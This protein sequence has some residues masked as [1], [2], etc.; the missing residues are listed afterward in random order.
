MAKKTKRDEFSEIEETKLTPEKEVKKNKKNKLISVI[1]YL[2]ARYNFRFNLFAAKPEF[3]RVDEALEAFRF[4]DERI[5]DSLLMEIKLDAGIDINKND[6]Q[7]LINSDKLSENFNPIMDYINGLPRWDGVD[8]FPLF[9]QQIQLMDEEKRGHLI[10][11]FKRWFV[12]MIANLISDTV[13]N[14]TC[15]VLSG[16]QGKGKTR[17]LESLVPKKL[18]FFYSYVGTFDPHNKDHLEMIGTKMQLILDEMETLTRTDQGTLK[19]AMSVKHIT[20][21]RAY[22]HA[23]IFLFR[24]ASF[25][26]SIN[27]DEFLTDTTGNRRWLPF[28][29]SNIDVDE[30]FDIDL[31][32][33]QA[34]AMFAEG[35][36]CWFNHDE[37]KEIEKENEKFRRPSPEEELIMVNYAVPTDSEVAAGTID[38]KRMTST[39]LMHT[40][41]SS[42]KYKKMNTND[43]VANRIGRTMQRMGF[44]QTSQ[45][46]DGKEYAVKVWLVKELSG[47]LGERVRRGE[48]LDDTA[49]N[50]LPF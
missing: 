25:C 26:G 34:K 48:P 3:K 24:K 28:A 4:I 5:F 22:G 49:V 39:D 8:R 42:D 47:Q 10:N 41:A 45:R 18:R 50:G 16:K 37:I 1:V 43:T 19:S 7:S 46:V 20:L 17:F 36:R 44:R 38:I 23:P 13:I 15:F 2:Q 30:S 31:L 33:A 9:L 27:Y 40:L 11:T 29:V 35:F 14:D 21:R 12:M 32:Y 6:F